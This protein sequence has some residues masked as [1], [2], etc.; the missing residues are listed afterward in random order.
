MVGFLLMINQITNFC[1]KRRHI[2][3]GIAIVMAAYGYIACQQMTVEAYPELSDVTVQIATQVP[4]LSA[5][6]IEQEITIPIERALTTTPDMM[7]YRSSSTFALSLITL[8]FRDSVP[9][10]YFARERTLNHYSDA[11]LPANI[12]SSINP[13]T[14]SGGE[15]YRY[16]LESDNKNLMELSDIQR[17]IVIPQLKSVPGIADV[18][19]FGG[20]T[21]EFQ[22]LVDPKK[23][24]Q[25]QISF[26]QIIQAIS[27]NT[28]NAGGGRVTRGQQTYVVRGIGQIHDLHDMGAVVVAQHNGVPILAKDLG[29]IQYGH[30]EREGILGKNNN[31]DTIEGIVQMYKYQNPSRVLQVLHQKIEQLQ[32]LLQPMGVK[33]VPYIDR[34][35]L[36]KLTIEKVSHTV[37]EGIILVFL[38]LV[39]FLGNPRSAVV[40]TVAI[41]ASLISVFILMNATNTPANLFSLGAIDFGIIVD[42][43]IVVL[44]AIL[45]HREDHPDKL[46][47]VEATLQIAGYVSKPIF[48]ST[49]VIISAYLPLFAFERAEG[50]LFKPMAFTVSYALLGALVCALTLIPGLAYTALRKPQ[51]IFHN[52]PLQWLTDRYQQALHRLLLQPRIAYL[53]GLLVILTVI[54]LGYSAGREF[55]PELDE[56]GLWLQVQ[57]PTGLSLEKAS[58]M[59]DNLRKTLLK[60]PE[61]SYVVTQLGRSDQ[62]LDPWTFS[63]IEAPVGLTPYANWP[64]GENKAK[65]IAALNREFAQI[66]G[67]TVGISQPIIDNVNDMIGGAHSPL[68]LR[69]YGDD[70]KEGRR[71]GNAVAHI[72]KSIRGTASSSVFQLPPVPQVVISIDRQKLARFGINI[73][74]VTTLIQTGLG[75]MPVANIYVDDRIYSATVRFRK[76]NKNN[77][78]SIGN[79][80][81]NSSTGVPILLSEIAKIEYKT[82]ESS[83][84]RENGERQITVRIDVRG[85]DLASYLAEA[86]MRIGKEITFDPHKVH[87]QWAGQFESEQRAQQRM[88]YILCLM[89]ILMSV[90]LFMQ[91]Q[92]LRYVVLILGIVPMA[93]LGGLISLHLTGETLNVATGVGF[94]AL[95]GVSVQNGI[96]MIANIRRVRP[97]SDSLLASV[98]DGATERLR[99]VLM[100]A[101]VASCGML[102]AAIATGVGTDVQRGLAT[103]VVGGLIVSTWL[104]LFI[105]PTY[106]YVLER[107][108]ETNLG[109]FKFKLAFNWRK[110]T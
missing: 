39:L 17:W 68:V 8:V 64:K 53:M 5:E 83:I 30:Q 29:R 88:I 46:L 3:W 89:I 23:M 99:P 70:L 54:I 36:V 110:K 4:G 57:L 96:I 22:L 56:G 26:N 40:A 41:P 65:F 34:D 35:N 58:E 55:L 109:H 90:L 38:V 87:L 31:S 59:A 6:E 62:G 77:L 101:T 106:Y 107:F 12:Q 60:H 79:L 33:I 52:R 102:P 37:I 103:V 19:N 93:A 97:H 92:K 13:L 63:H 69:I 85:R 43:A 98:I 20:F 80:F 105:L 74:D 27:N 75:G 42:G 44:E 16:T 9:D 1:F 18:A 81:I 91:F 24:Q 49:L 84:S 66:P 7:F 45:R 61:I 47:S 48:F 76:S 72:L 11:I 10:D 15:I 94:I 28:S 67:V 104:T 86:Q 73:A 25:Y 82:G 95:C 32:Q 14:G 51:K 108:Y 50:R 78:E 71:I 21:R 100:T 2:A